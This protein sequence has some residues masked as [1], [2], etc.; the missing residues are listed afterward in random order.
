MCSETYQVIKLNGSDT[1]IHTR[2]DLLG[3]GNGVNMVGVESVTQ[4]RYTGGDLVE[5]D[6]L[7]AAICPTSESSGNVKGWHREKHTSLLD[8]HG[9]ACACVGSEG[10]QER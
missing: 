7:L 2:D 8:I 10:A 5:L 1:T 6:T 9:D 3:D 4:T